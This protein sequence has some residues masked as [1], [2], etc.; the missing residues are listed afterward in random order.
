MLGSLTLLIAAARAQ[1]IEVHIDPNLAAQ[2]GLSEQEVA[3]MESSMNEATRGQLKLDAPEAWLVQ[4]AEA[5]AF[6]T[7]GMG[8][9]YATNPQTFVLGGSIGTAVNGAGFQF[10]K[11]GQDLPEAGFAF[12]ASAMAGVNLGALSSKESFLRRFVL[13]ANGMMAGGASGP[14]EADL[15]N[16][17]AHLQFKLIKPPSLGVVEWGGLDLTGGWEASN[18]KLKLSQAIPVDGEQLRW[19]ATGTFDVA[20]HSESVPLEVSTNLRVFVVSAYLGA[21]VDLR[22][23]A[24]AQSSLSLDGPIWLTVSQPETEIG[25]ARAS[26]EAGGDGVEVVPRAF[27]GAQI[28]VLFVKVYGHLNVGLDDRY[29]G[30]LGVRVAI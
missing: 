11:G 22:Q 17:G 16:Y 3:A 9:D 15:N 19:D 29:S 12:Q 2:A 4:M 7:K 1:S 25:S 5:N 24:H 10:V 6:A 27:A 20:A 23:A 28:N 13:Y 18:Y 21:G 14:F 8:V 26:L 30:H